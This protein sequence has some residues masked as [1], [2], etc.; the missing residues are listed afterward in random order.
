[1]DDTERECRKL[2]AELNTNAT[3]REALE[4]KYGKVWTLEELQKEF[5]IL[6]FQAPFV[7]VKRLSDNKLGSVNFQHLPRFYFNWAEHKE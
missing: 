6:Q 3:D 1:M 7:V 5:E 4:A 2:Q